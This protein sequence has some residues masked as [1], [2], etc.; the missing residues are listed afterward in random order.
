MRFAILS[1]AGKEITSVVLTLLL[2]MPLSMASAAPVVNS[3]ADYDIPISEL[4]KVRKKS[5]SK[6]V[7][8]ESGKKKK[9][10]AKSGASSPEKTEPVGLV[11]SP[12]IEAINSTQIDLP[13]KI[14]PGADKPLPDQ[15]II[16]IHHSPYSFVVAGK[17]TI[18]YAVISS[19][20]DTKEIMC[21]IRTA[22]GVAPIL[23]KMEKVRDTQFTYTATLPGLSSETGSLRYTIIAVDSLG[24]ETRSH[25]FVTPV[26]SSPVVPGWQLESAG[27]AISVDKNEENKH[28]DPVIN[29]VP[30]NPP[31]K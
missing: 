23:V 28:N 13:D 25:E 16:Q 2:V 20:A 15:E 19:K 4:N 31:A 5:P 1:S 29:T 22:E 6:R 17:R 11:K 7:T 24:K 3:V 18:I 10:E 27:E 26:T 21:S 30:K 8:G 14:T 12:P 9:S